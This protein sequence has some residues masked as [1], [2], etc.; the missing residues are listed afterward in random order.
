MT[1]DAHGGEAPSVR[2]DVMARHLEQ[3]TADLVRL[4]EALKHQD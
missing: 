4:R 1:P 2:L 3:L